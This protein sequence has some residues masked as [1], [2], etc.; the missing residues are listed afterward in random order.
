MK[1]FLPLLGTFLLILPPLSGQS[2]EVLLLGTYKGAGVTAS[3]YD[4]IGELL[5]SELVKRKYSLAGSIQKKSCREQKCQIESGQ[6]KNANLVLSYS[7]SKLGSNY[8]LSMNWLDVDQAKV[9][10]NERVRVAKIEDLESQIPQAI[11]ALSN[12]SLVQK[13]E[14]PTKNQYRGDVQVT[15]TTNGRAIYIDGKNSRKKTPGTISLVYGSEYIISMYDP[16]G[17]KESYQIVLKK[18]EKKVVHFSFPNRQNQ[19]TIWPNSKQQTE[20][21]ESSSTKFGFGF[22]PVQ[23][24]PHGTPKFFQF[25]L[26]YGK[27]RDIFGVN[28][29]LGVN[30]HEEGKYQD[31]FLREANMQGFELGLLN[32]NRGEIKG[33]QVGAINF[34]RGGSGLQL[35]I[36]DNLNSGSFHG[37][38]IGLGFP[39]ISINKNSGDFTGWQF[40]SFLNINESDFVGLQSSLLLN[41]NNQDHSGVQFSA[42][43][44]NI[45]AGSQT[46][47]QITSLLNMNSGDNHGVQIAA[48]NYSKGVVS[49]GQAGL[50]NHAAISSNFQFGAYNYSGGDTT[51]QLGLINYSAQKAKLQVGLINYAKENP[52]PFLPLV[53]VN[54]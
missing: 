19:K 32:L 37:V 28:L 33:A 41:V 39:L 29:G 30:S 8:I 10:T 24:N 27:I 38:Q 2:L 53:N 42:I 44:A 3:D 47:L 4:S 36:M 1:R 16:K 51:F 43:A 13:T 48:I 11:D 34:T 22:G 31:G 15:S 9:I 46:G 25:S 21:D 35:G 5:R 7:L 12:T 52:I 50:Y 6:E 17:M 23:A 14:Q 49:Y 20:S 45:N 26:F 40:G 54:Y 18:G